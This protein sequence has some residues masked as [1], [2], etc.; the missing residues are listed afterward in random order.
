[1]NERCMKGEPVPDTG[2]MMA[3]MTAGEEERRTACLA[4]GRCRQPKESPCPNGRQRGRR[5]HIPLNPPGRPCPLESLGPAGGALPAPPSKI[6]HALSD[7]PIS[8]A[9]S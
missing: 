5:P 6:A 1:M 3:L 9:G 2:R 8:L 4:G 7:R